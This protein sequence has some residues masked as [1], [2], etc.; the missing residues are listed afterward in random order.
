[1]QDPK[2][3]T[4]D[5]INGVCRELELTSILCIAGNV[6]YACQK[7]NVH[8]CGFGPGPTPSPSP[9]PTPEPCQYCN[10]P[11]ALRPADCS[12]PANPKCDPFLEYQLSGCCYQQTCERVGIT[13]PPP[14]PCPPG[15][16]RSSNQLQPFP[17][18]SLPGVR[19]GSS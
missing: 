14:Q 10:D 3:P 15:Y 16:S 9:T 13:P 7:I 6:I 4:G 8:E 11:N 1:M 17:K 2:R 5:Q 18:C 19:T 12:D